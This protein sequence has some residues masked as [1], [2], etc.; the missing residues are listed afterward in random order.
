MTQLLDT[1]RR[2]ETPEGVDLGLHPAGPAVRSLAFALDTGIRLALYL[3]IALP[4]AI[5]GFG[6]GMLLIGIFLLE[7]VYPVVFEVWTGATPGKRAMGLAVVHDD[8]TPVGLPGSAIRN[9]LRAIDFLPIFYGVGLVST[10]VDRDFRRLGDLAA[11]TLVIHVDQ[12]AGGAAE[13]QAGRRADDRAGDAAAR[14]QARATPPPGLALATAQAILAFDERAARLSP[15][16]RIELAETLLAQLRDGDDRPAAP[17]GP[18]AVTQVRGLRAVAGRSD[19][20]SLREPVHHTRS[21]QVSHSMRQEPFE[22]TRAGDW[23]ACRRLLDTLEHRGKARRADPALAHFP[24]LYRRV[25]ADYALARTRRY[26]PGLIAQ[27][28]DL[29]RRGHRCLYQRRPALL[30][31]TLNFM[32]AGFPRTLR[33]QARVCW[34]AAALL[35]LPMAIMGTACWQDGELIHSLM[36]DSAVADLESLYDPMRQRP[37]RSPERQADTDLRM[38][39]FYIYNNIGIG[40]RTF[41][42]GLLLGIGSVVILVFNGLF[43]GAAAGHL[44]RLG[45]GSTFWPFVSGH[46]PFEL[47]AIA[48]SGAAGLLL[49]LALIAPGR[50]TRLAALRA[51]ARD[52][53]ALVG[54]AAILLLLAAVV[55]AFWSAGSAPSAVKYGVGALGWLLVAA[56]L[57]L[58]GREAEVARGCCQD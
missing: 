15:A 9:L 14:S 4:L 16:R 19:T 55:E 23:E 33:R 6:G 42:A 38:F 41:A 49:G 50:R 29:V 35:F 27:L 18:A 8:G 40:F 36:D 20:D 2:Y 51:N 48:I 26:S 44:T 34:L 25:C 52:A 5:A 3:A 7:W 53:V 47:T 17:Q 11:G 31:P 43:I 1:V 13:G 32:A 21:S 56:Y 30:A 10:L 28:H 57:G 37:G 22:T 54:G 24:V 12:R 46:S 45:Q 58:A 39:G